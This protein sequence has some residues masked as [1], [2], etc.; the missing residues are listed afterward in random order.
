[1][2][3]ILNNITMKEMLKNHQIKAVS[4]SKN[5]LEHSS[6]FSKL[7]IEYPDLAYGFN[8]LLRLRN[9]YQNINVKFVK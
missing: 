3:T 2:V 8:W 5:L 9:I 4:Y 1:M 7:E 6:D